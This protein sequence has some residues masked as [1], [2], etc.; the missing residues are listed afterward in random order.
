MTALGWTLLLKARTKRADAPEN[1]PPNLEPYLTAERA[2]PDNPD[3]R[4]FLAQEYDRIGETELAL[5]CMEQVTQM[6]PEWPAPWSE[7]SR[8]LLSRGQTHDAVA[9]AQA[10]CDRFPKSFDDHLALEKALHA[11]LPSQ[12]S[13]AE[14]QPV[15]ALAHQLR[16]SRPNDQSVLVDEVDL[17]ARMGQRSE[18]AEL[19]LSAG[20]DAAPAQPATLAALSSV[21]RDQHLD[22]AEQLVHEAASTPLTSPTDAAAIFEVFINAG[23]TAKAGQLLSTLRQQSGDGWTLAWLKARDRLFGFN[24]AGSTTA[25]SASGDWAKF[26]DAHPD[27]FSIQR[28]TLQSATAGVDRALIDRTIDRFRKLTGEDCIEWKLARA[29]WLLSAT[30][31][32]QARASTAAELMADAAR[33]CPDDTQ[34]RVLWAESL[35]KANDINGAI[36]GLQLAVK[37]QPHDT[38]IAQKLADLMAQRQGENAKKPASAAVDPKP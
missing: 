22:L 17:L 4:Y 15:L 1:A 28:A 7:I 13:A 18:A 20:S 2:N 37:L 38:R 6:Q 9:P 25:G 31:D 23:E 35:A 29:R 26:A 21:D 8:I 10:A 24:T 30:T 11:N 19:A 34:P 3:A 14:I 27:V 5:R 36:A 12:A 16:T 32:V 33:A